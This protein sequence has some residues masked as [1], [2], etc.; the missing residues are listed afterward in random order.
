MKYYRVIKEN[1]LWD[2]WAILE[3]KS[4]PDRGHHYAAISEVFV[5]NEPPINRSFEVISEYVVENQPE[6]FERVYN[7]DTVLWQLYKTKDQMKA[8]LVEKYNNISE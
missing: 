2:V 6:Y 4:Y 3:R 1:F 8:Y 5:K 7:T